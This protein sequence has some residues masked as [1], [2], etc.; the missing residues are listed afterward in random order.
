MLNVTPLK[1][2]VMNK[3][4]ESIVALPFSEHQGGIHQ[5]LRKIMEHT[6][7]GFVSDGDTGFMVRDINISRI[8]T[9]RVF[10]VASV[11]DSEEPTITHSVSDSFHTDLSLREAV[12]HYLISSALNEAKRMVVSF[13]ENFNYNPSELQIEEFLNAERMRG[14]LNR[15]SSEIHQSLHISRLF[16]A[17]ERRDRP[18]FFAFSITP[19]LGSELMLA[20]LSQV[21]NPFLEYG[22]E[23]EELTQNLMPPSVQEKR[24]VFINSSD[25]YNYTEEYQRNE[26]PF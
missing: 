20:E 10:F 5:Y 8:P 25:E 12:P 23:E 1:E 26:L 4:V 21:D 14:H 3:L 7:S 22:G 15:Y 13:L 16:R 19:Y 24:E 17:R 6:N 18:F 2:K 9:D 11:S